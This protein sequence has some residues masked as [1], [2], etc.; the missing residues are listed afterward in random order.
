MGLRV[1]DEVEWEYGVDQYG[2]LGLPGGDLAVAVDGVDNGEEDRS[3]AP[4][5]GK[6]C[7]GR[8]ESMW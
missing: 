4:E 7:F 3:V 8:C 1:G 2:E 5:C 6:C